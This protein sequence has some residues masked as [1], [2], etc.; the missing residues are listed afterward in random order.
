[1]RRRRRYYEPEDL[2]REQRR[3]DAADP[4]RRF[5]VYVLDTDYGHY[6]GHTADVG[7]RL[8]QHQDDQ[9]GST[10]GGNPS[11][12]WT[13]GPNATRRDAASFEAAM[14]SYREQRSPRF[15]EITGVAPLPWRH[16]R[17]RA[18]SLVPASRRRTRRT[19]RRRRG[20]SGRRVLRT[21]LG[22]V[23][24]AV[25]VGRLD[26]FEAIGNALP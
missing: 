16:H 10:S 21:V 11:L 19:G 1:M 24:V 4:S 5:Y 20:R 6:V 9:V 14:K 8:R 13:S 2:G 3:R 23:V 12:V 18:G 15:E 7:A 17:R 26:V 25:V 22:I